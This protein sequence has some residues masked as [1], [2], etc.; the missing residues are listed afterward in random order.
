MREGSFVMEEHDL[1]LNLGV[2]CN[3]C[4]Y[5]SRKLPDVEGLTALQRQAIEDLCRLCIA[6]FHPSAVNG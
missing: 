6:T 5:R 2:L 4:D 3:C 1:T